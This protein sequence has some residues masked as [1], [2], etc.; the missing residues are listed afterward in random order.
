MTTA[1]LIVLRTSVAHCIIG[2]EEWSYG[3][4]LELI[5]ATTIRVA[6]TLNVTEPAEFF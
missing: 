2:L 1:P 5:A 6:A 3:Q 4:R